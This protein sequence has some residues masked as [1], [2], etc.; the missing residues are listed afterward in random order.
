MKYLSVFSYN[1]HHIYNNY[2]TPKI[3]LT[4]LILFMNSFLCMFEEVLI[5]YIS[6]RNTEM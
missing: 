5:K 2:S 3:K 1:D 4:L 6:F